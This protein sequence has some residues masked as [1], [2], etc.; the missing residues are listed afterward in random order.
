[1]SVNRFVVWQVEETA[2][3][4]S[5]WVGI[6]AGR[7][8][9]DGSVTGQLPEPYRLSYLLETDDRSATTRLVVACQTGTG[10]RELELRRD[11]TL[12]T[13]NGVTRP[14]LAGALDCDL[15]CSP[16]TNTMPVL[17]HN[18]HIRPGTHEFTMAFVEVPTLRVIPSAQT[19]THLGPESTG[20][21]RVRYAAGSFSS[22]L[23]FD[24]DGLVL[25][26]PTMA[27]RIEP[28]ESVT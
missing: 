13:V 15:G 17:R 26:Y 24:P 19:Y 10:Q 27:H 12:W 28:V 3:F 11:G 20:G 14:D 25:T 16:V 21:V 2:G 4:E 7:V 9:A 18:L 1:M 22:D 8:R 6:D 5:A 23:L